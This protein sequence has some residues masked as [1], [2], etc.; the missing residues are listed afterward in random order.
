MTT[1]VFHACSL[2]DGVDSAAVSVKPECG[3]VEVGA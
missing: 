3:V 2:V 1:A